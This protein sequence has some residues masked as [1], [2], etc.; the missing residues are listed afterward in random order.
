MFWR[1]DKKRNNKS[2]Q[3]PNNGPDSHKWE[4]KMEI[5]RLISGKPDLTIEPL[6]KSTSYPAL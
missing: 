5:I 2:A 4:T 3:P 1:R 6:S